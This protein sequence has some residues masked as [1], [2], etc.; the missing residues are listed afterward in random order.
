MAASARGWQRVEVEV[1]WLRRWCGYTKISSVARVCCCHGRRL[2]QWVLLGSDLG[3]RL[4]QQLRALILS[5]CFGGRHL[6]LYF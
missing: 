4:R 5:G 1:S 3:L 2:L 6:L